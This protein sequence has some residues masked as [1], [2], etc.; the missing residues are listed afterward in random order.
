MLAVLVW[1]WHRVQPPW[2]DTTADVAEMLDNQ[3]SNV[4]YEGTDEYVPTGADAYDKHQ[5]LQASDA[6]PCRTSLPCRFGSRSHRLCR[7]LVP[8]YCAM[9]G[10]GEWKHPGKFL[11][12]FG[13]RNVWTGMGLEDPYR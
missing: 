8:R 7:F 3:E 10:R 5:Q 11:T 6:V 9:K 13:F 4:G 1:V 2:W 12:H